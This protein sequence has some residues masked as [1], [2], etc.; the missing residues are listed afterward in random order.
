MNRPSLF[1]IYILLCFEMDLGTDLLAAILVKGLK[2][3]TN[4]KASLF[5]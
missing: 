2:S 3:T 5:Q 4:M 1:S